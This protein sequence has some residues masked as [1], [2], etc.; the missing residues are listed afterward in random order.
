MKRK[1]PDFTETERWVVDTTLK[2]RYGKPVEVKAADVEMRLSP[3]DRELTSCPALFWA[4]RDA[5][6]VLSKTGEGLFRC[7]FYYSVREQY[8][9]GRE[10]YDDLAECVTAL[11]K[12]QADHEAQRQGTV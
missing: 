1:I 9:T 12:L 8:G 2:E 4:E 3:A 5:G 6:F 10:E 11:L 7:Q